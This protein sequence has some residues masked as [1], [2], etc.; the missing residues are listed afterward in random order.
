M[1]EGHE[2]VFMS[3]NINTANKRNSEV[4]QQVRFHERCDEA[5]TGRIDVDLHV[6][7]F[8]L[9]LLLKEVRE[10]GDVFVLPISQI[11]IA[12]TR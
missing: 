11:S 8:L 4:P 3:T 12:D 6:Q 1:M 10:R 2:P 5:T 9:V 7:P